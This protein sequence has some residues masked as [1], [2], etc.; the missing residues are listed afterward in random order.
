MARIVIV[1]VLNSFVVILIFFVFLSIGG[2]FIM[3]G[4]KRSVVILFSSFLFSRWEVHN[5]WFKNLLCY[6]LTVV[7]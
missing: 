5:D 6:Y 2:K 3:I 4:F 1:D 7:V